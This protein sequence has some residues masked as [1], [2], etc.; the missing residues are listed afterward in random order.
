MFANGIT[1]KSTNFVGKLTVDKQTHRLNKAFHERMKLTSYTLSMK[2]P[3]DNVIW[4]QRRLDYKSKHVTNLICHL[5]YP[6]CPSVKSPQS[7]RLHQAVL[8]T[9]YCYQQLEWAAEQYWTGH[10]YVNNCMILLMF[11]L[12]IAFVP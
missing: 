9:I 2:Q 8:I 6:I 1:G 7:E 4:W 3:P 11:V 12:V 5:Q 10:F